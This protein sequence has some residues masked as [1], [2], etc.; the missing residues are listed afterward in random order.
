VTKQRPRN[1]TMI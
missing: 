1:R